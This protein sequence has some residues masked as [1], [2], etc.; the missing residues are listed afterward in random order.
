MRMKPLT[1]AQILYL[2]ERSAAAFQEGY[3]K[4]VE[5]HKQKLK[6]LSDICQAGSIVVESMSKALLSLNGNL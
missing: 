4:G 1:S 3:N 2:K 5:E 6:A